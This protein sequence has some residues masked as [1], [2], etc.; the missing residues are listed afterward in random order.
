MVNDLADLRKQNPKASVR[1]GEKQNP[2]K[3]Q[4][5]AILRTSKSGIKVGLRTSTMNECPF[6]TQLR[7]LD[8]LPHFS[9]KLEFYCMENLKQ[10]PWDGKHQ[11][12][13]WVRG[14]YSK[15]GDQVKV[16]I[17]NVK[18]SNLLSTTC[19]TEACSQA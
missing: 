18:T 8:P 7:V 10:S 17:L 15:Q 4:K 9:K 12:Q 3:V 14:T 13:M 2:P 11:A 19:L 5:L 16:Y 6:K 1:K